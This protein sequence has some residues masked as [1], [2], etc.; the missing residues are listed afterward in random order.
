MLK[1]GV[2]AGSLVIALLCGVSNCN[3]SV[4]VLLVFGTHHGCCSFTPYSKKIR[5]RNEK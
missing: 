4:F 2:V 3:V 1:F 5:G